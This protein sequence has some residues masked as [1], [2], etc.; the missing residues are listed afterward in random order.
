MLFRTKENI[1]IAVH[2][3]SCYHMKPKFKIRHLYTIGVPLFIETSKQRDCF[4]CH[5]SS[6][7]FE[8]FPSK[9]ITTNKNF[10]ILKIVKDTGTVNSIKLHDELQMFNHNDDNKISTNENVVVDPRLKSKPIQHLRV[11]QMQRQYRSTSSKFLICTSIVY[12]LYT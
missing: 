9:N 10:R 7:T 4:R 11:T 3:S 1:K 12:F 8:T 6:C 5:Y 2:L